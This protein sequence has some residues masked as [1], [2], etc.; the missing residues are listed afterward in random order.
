MANRG[1]TPNEVAVIAVVITVA[2]AAVP[3]TAAVINDNAITST[4]DKLQELS[5][6]K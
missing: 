3:L 4:V 5:Q 2:T 1:L 6:S